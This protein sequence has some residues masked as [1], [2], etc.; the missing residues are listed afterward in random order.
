MKKVYRLEKLCL[1][2]LQLSNT[3]IRVVKEIPLVALWSVK[4]LL[5]NLCGLFLENA[6]LLEALDGDNNNI[7][8]ISHQD[9]L[10]FLCAIW[11]ISEVTAIQ[12][13]QV[14]E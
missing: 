11:G 1:S 5:N 2:Y 7:I 10:S 4:V 8:H 9:L 13:N 6:L 12:N 3:Y 14:L